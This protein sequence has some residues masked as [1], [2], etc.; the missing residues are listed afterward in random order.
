[1]EYCNGGDLEQAIKKNLS[2]DTKNKYFLQIIEG[3]KELHTK[4]ISKK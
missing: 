2:K 1:L 4:N 3:V